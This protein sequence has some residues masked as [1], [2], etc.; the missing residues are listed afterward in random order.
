MATTNS[1]DFLR[2]LTRGMAVETLS[3][4][5]DRQLVERALAGRDEAAFQAIVQRHG[6]MVYRVCWRVLLHP[7]DAE[8]AFQATFLVLAQKLRAVRKRPSLASWLHGVARRVALK[9]KAQAAGRRRHEHDVS[10]PATA[11]PDD[12]TWKELR[13][14]LDAELGTLPEKWRLPLILCYLE[15]R[16]QDEAASQLAWSKS[17]LRRRLEEARDALGRRLNGRGVVWPAALSAVL[18]SECIASAAPGLVASTVEAAARVAAGK[19]VATAAS[20]KVAALTEGVLKAMLITKVKAG[21][22]V[23]LMLG[24]VGL[25]CGVLAFGMTSA[26]GDDV[27]KPAAKAN[28]KADMLT[29]TIKPQKN[30]VRV[31]EPFKVDLRVV[32]SSKAAQSFQVMSCS[33]DEHW[34]SS[35]DRVSWEGWPCAENSAVTVKL[36]PG[37]AYEK[38]LPM[39]LPAGKPQEKVSFKMGF[40]PIG[41]KQTFWSD[42]VTVQVEPDHASKTDQE[43]IQGAW[44]AESGPWKWASFK[45]DIGSFDQITNGFPFQFNLDPAKKPKQMDIVTRADP[46]GKEPY[47]AKIAAIYSLEGDTLKICYAQ[48]GKPRPTE[49]AAK[50]DGEHTLLVL[51]RGVAPAKPALPNR[52]EKLLQNKDLTAKQRAAYE[53]IA[54]LHTVKLEQEDR[55]A[56]S[57]PSFV[58][59]SKVPTDLLFQMGLDAL[60]MLAEALDDET[61][62]VTVTDN[63]GRD[64]RVW[65]VNDLVGL[66]IWRIAERDF[67][68]GEPQKELGIRDI[69]Q[70]PKAAAEFRKLVV[71]WHGKFAAKTPTERKIADVTDTW[72]RNR[73][74]AIIWLGWTRAKEGRAPIAARVDAY[75]ADEKRSVDSTT[76]AEMT[77]CAQALGQIGDRAS[78]PQVR[79]VC[80]DL[81]H[82]V[83]MSY[84]PLDQGRRGGGSSLNENLFRAYDG[85]ALLGEKEEAVK[86]LQR[87]LTTYG[88]EMEASTRKDYEERL[89]AAKGEAPKEA[90]GAKKGTAIDLQFHPSATATDLK[91]ELTTAAKATRPHQASYLAVTVTNRSTDEILTG[92]AR[93]WGGGKGPA[94]LPFTLLHASI[95][96]V[97]E[98]KAP[99]FEPAYQAGDAAH[100]S[101]LDPVIIA[102]GKSAEFLLRMDWPGAGFV[103]AR[104]FP[105]AGGSY[106]VQVLLV[107]QKTGKTPQKMQYVMSE[108]TMVE[109]PGLKPLGPKPEPWTGEPVIDRDTL[110]GGKKLSTFK[111]LPKAADATLLRI[112]CYSFKPTAD[113]TAANFPKVL[114]SMKTVIAGDPKYMSNNLAHWSYAQFE[115]PEGR[116]QV[117]FYLGGQALLTAPDGSAGRVTFDLPKLPLPG[118]NAPLPELVKGCKGALVATLQEVGAPEV[119]PPG[120][121]DYASKWKVERVLRGDYPKTTDLSFRVQSLPEKSREKPPAIGKT[122]ILITH[123]ANA[124]QIAAVLEA[125]EKILRE[126]QDLLRR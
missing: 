115:T 75:Y 96:P 110:T 88:A 5:S 28:E 82:A 12:V 51:K 32:N 42:E 10:R 47:V 63:R 25:T 48:P 94:K 91:I 86:E 59:N 67:V 74:D 125:D 106:K 20:V 64:K 97:K 55:G 62:T 24:M 101:I 105:D 46:E 87:L 99:A 23:L 124:G 103:P 73:F 65:K 112:N 126:V 15:G 102:A 69:A 29:V 44:N 33:W 122:Y 114:D 58:E 14:A 79:R 4:H 85:L 1:S 8:D 83:Y 121:A 2:C 50:P 57:I 95:V 60:P 37:E 30:P 3:D 100:D 54:K 93:E 108:P 89:K 109:V 80:A 41:S 90:D 76:Q 107:F 19:T 18:L 38:T 72:F 70:R 52:W 43:L 61:P 119:G 98:T 77:H 11:P 27:E 31:K 56:I 111:R 53:Q 117:E 7:Q 81:S 21:A 13:S 9:A 22:L 120:A 118:G 34:K 78:L 116:F 49:F 17:T 68:I 123:E 84:R 6:P 40:T 104:Q 39:L 36:E 92:I 16:T 35:N 26:N 66:L 71:A 45:V 113:L